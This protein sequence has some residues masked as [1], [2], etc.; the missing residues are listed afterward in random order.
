MKFNVEKDKLETRYA[1]LTFLPWIVPFFMIAFSGFLSLTVAQPL[2]N[3]YREYRS[4][5]YR[6]NPIYAHSEIHQFNNV[7]IQFNG[8]GHRACYFSASINGIEIALISALKA[9]KSRELGIPYNCGDVKQ[10]SGQYK[11]QMHVNKLKLEYFDGKYYLLS[12]KGKGL[13]GQNIDIEIKDKMT[14]NEKYTIFIRKEPHW[15]IFLYL[16]LIY[17][18]SFITY[19]IIIIF[20]IQRHK[21]RLRH[22]IQNISP[23]FFD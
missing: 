20:L 16:T 18:P 2:G 9:E 11:M 6:N 22:Q 5:L 19:S 8:E 15:L 21:K 1:M 23:H 3:A 13:R 17:P 10:Y 12:W 14:P 4:N 7:Y